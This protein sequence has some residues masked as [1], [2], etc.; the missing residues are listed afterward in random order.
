MLNSSVAV[1][2]GNKDILSNHQLVLSVFMKIYLI[3]D[4]KMI[5]SQNLNVV[6]FLQTCVF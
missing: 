1:G 3:T 5:E 6:K 2:E 4:M